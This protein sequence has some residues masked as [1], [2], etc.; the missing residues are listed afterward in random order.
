MFGVV[1]HKGQSCQDSVND[2][3]GYE[4]NEIGEIELG[5]VVLKLVP[6]NGV[7]QVNRRKQEPKKGV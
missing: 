1:F 2:Q 5:D 6:E 7:T 3:K 4:G